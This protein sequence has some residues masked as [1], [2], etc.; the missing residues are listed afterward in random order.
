M[1]TL[2]AYMCI[3]CIC[4]HIHYMIIQVCIMNICAIG[5]YAYYMCVV[6]ACIHYVYVPYG[7]IMHI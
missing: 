6:C 5:I 3:L 7:Y 4:V 1:S 2:Y